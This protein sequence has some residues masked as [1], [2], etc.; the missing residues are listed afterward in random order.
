M[1]LG[2]QD[3]FKENNPVYKRYGKT[4]DFVTDTCKDLDKF[5]ELNQYENNWNTLDY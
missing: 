3:Y 5:E 4:G 1:T 2:G